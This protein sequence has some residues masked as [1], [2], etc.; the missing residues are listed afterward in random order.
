MTG[1]HVCGSDMLPSR[2]PLLQLLLTRRSRIIPAH[3]IES[4]CAAVLP[5]NAISE[6]KSFDA[7]RAN[8]RI[9]DASSG[10]ASAELIGG[11]F[12][13]PVM[14][15]AAECIVRC[16][17]VRDPPAVEAVVLFGSAS[18]ARLRPL[19]CCET[20]P[21]MMMSLRTCGE[22]LM[23]IRQPFVARRASPWVTSGNLVYL[24]R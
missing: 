2:H 21:A 4:S 16:G 12:D 15:Q 8:D 11:D 3:G 1:H 24:A 19:S 22:R 5:S 13:A 14:G 20:H 7:V 6:G 23:V 17:W 9:P 18:R 10:S